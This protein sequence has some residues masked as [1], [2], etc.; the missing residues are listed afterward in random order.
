MLELKLGAIRNSC[1][2]GCE[3]DY[4]QLTNEVGIKLMRTNEDTAKTI[5]K[6][7]L[8]GAERGWAPKVI[9]MAKVTV[10]GHH[11]FGVLTE[12]VPTLGIDVGFAE[13]EAILAALQKAMA[14]D[15]LSLQD[16]HGGNYGRMS[17]GMPAIVDCGGVFPKDGWGKPMPACVTEQVIPEAPES[18]GPMILSCLAKKA[19]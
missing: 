6:R 18:Y 13:A 15:N 19:K 17:D 10:G 11:C 12:H 4:Y 14:T 2:S 1:G 7:Q 16:C 5:V 3:S 9:G 8:L